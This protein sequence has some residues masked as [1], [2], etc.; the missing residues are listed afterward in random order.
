MKGL[1]ALAAPVLV[2]LMS[3]GMG[4]QGSSTSPVAFVGVNVL[5]MDR[6]VVLLQ[7]GS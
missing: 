4:A 7:S 6:E 1:M 2:R 5:P 3:C